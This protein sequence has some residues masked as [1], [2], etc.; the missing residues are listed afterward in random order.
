M[1]QNEIITGN[2]YL[3]ANTD[4]EHRKNMIGTIVTVVSRKQGNK[5]PNFQGGMLTG[6]GKKPI[7]FKLSNGQWANAANLKPNQP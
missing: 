6:I 7:R 5:K 3:F 1:K 2:S 4:V